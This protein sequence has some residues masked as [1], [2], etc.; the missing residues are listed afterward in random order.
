MYVNPEYRRLGVG[1]GLVQKLREISDQGGCDRI[2]GVVLNQ[3]LIAKKF[4]DKIEGA[5]PVD[6]AHVVRIQSKL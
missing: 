5:K 2:E 6:Y 4:C 1:Q 3:N